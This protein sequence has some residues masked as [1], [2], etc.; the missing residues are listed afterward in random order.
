[1]PADAVGLAVFHG[2]RLLGLDVF[3][4]HSTLQY[5]WESLLDSYA[6]DWLG[7]PGLNSK[8]KASFEG[9][10]ISKTLDRAAAADWEDFASPGEGRDYRVQEK[11]W[12]GSA[13]VWEERTVIHLQIFPQA[14]DSQPRRRPRIH[15]VY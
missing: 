12:T 2:K 8:E 9:D 4:R 11:G 1:M 7:M 10:V 6:I 14:A 13:L 3:D 15:R 5:F